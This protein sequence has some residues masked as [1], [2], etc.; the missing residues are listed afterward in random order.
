MGLAQGQGVSCP[1]SLDAAGPQGWARP[2][3]CHPAAGDL[4]WERPPLGAAW[5]GRK[6]LL[7][8]CL[9]PGSAQ[10]LDLTCSPGFPLHVLFLPSA[11]PH[12]ARCP[13]RASAAALPFPCS[14]D[15]RA[16]FSRLLPI[17]SWW[18]WIIPPLSLSRTVILPAKLLFPLLKTNG[19]T[20]P[21]AGW[22]N[23]P[24]PGSMS[25]AFSPA[26]HPCQ[27]L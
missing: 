8:P 16:R 20:P 13:P 26:A 18:D 25:Q 3:D 22:R 24:R 17:Q 2:V 1:R 7:C 27:G 14:G 10:H 23:S 4:R 5:H 9:S 6:R 12:S 11:L 15:R 21:S 19:D